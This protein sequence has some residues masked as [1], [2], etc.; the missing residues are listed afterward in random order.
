MLLVFTVEWE[1]QT[2]FQSSLSF[3]LHTVIMVID[4]QNNRSATDIMIIIMLMNASHSN[5]MFHRAFY[6]LSFLKQIMSPIYLAHF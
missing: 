3:I 2:Q 6:H 1:L 4:P 5:I